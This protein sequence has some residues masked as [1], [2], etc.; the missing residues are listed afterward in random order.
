MQ[1]PAMGLQ[2]LSAAHAHPCSNAHAHS[3]HTCALGR[4]QL[5]VQSI[6]LPWTAWA[7]NSNGHRSTGGGDAGARLHANRERPPATP[8]LWPRQAAMSCAVFASMTG[9]WGSGGGGSGGGSGSSGGGDGGWH[10][11]D[12]GAVPGS[13]GAPASNVLADVALNEA[14]DMVEEV[15]LMDVGGA[16]CDGVQSPCLCDH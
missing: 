7:S 15:I 8:P 10:G 3:A 11:G 2:R 13:G 16:W 1:L 4:R 9:T 14:P 5:R 6:K 12:G